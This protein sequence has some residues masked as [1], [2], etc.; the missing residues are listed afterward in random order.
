VDSIAI[1]RRSL[2]NLAL[3]Y[4]MSLED[5]EAVELCLG[6]FHNGHAMTDVIAALGML[7]DTDLPERGPALEH[8]YERWNA[9]ALVV[10]K[11]FSI[12]AMSQRADALA[13]VRRL[14]DHPAFEIRNPN[15]VYALIGGFAGGNPVR[16]HDPS[17]GGYEFLADQVLRLDRLNP[18]VASRMV[19]MFARWRKYDAQ[20]QGLMRAQLER[21][22]KTEGLSR[23]VFEIASK[24]LEGA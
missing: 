9:E 13:D 14:L 2:K 23:D 12:Q 4:L 1:G 21:I 10:D 19:K 6:Q 18:Q 3:G 20:R 16:F 5:R 15:K 24:S 17:G 8:F 11:W 7:A 22:V